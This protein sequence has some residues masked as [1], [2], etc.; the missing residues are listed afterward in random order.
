MFMNRNTTLLWFFSLGILVCLLTACNAS[1]TS[2]PTPTLRP[3][4]TP[5][6]VFDPESN[7]LPTHPPLPEPTFN[8]PTVPPINWSATVQAQVTEI[9]CIPMMPDDWIWYQVQVG[10]TLESL[11]QR[12]GATVAELAQVNCLEENSVLADQTMIF[13]PGQ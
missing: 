6:P 5:F 1:P 7:I 10:D 4:A 8:P 12:T 13:I 3:T 2:A 9:A 11:A